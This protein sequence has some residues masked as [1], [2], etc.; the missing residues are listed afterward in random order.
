MKFPIERYTNEEKK[1]GKITE[2]KLFIAM[3]II[4]IVAIVVLAIGGY[5]N[6]K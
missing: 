2:N 4:I 6:L 5:V 3:M 1:K